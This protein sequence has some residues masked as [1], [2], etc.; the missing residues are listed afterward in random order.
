[1]LD[2]CLY[3]RPTD[4]FVSGAWGGKARAFGQRYERLDAFAETS[5]PPAALMMV[6]ETALEA[7]GRCAS[8]ML[9]TRDLSQTEQFF[10]SQSASGRTTLIGR[11]VSAVI[12]TGDEQDGSMVAS[13][14][15]LPSVRRFARHSGSAV[16]KAFEAEVIILQD[17]SLDVPSAYR[18]MATLLHAS[19]LPLHV[20][21]DLA[22]RIVVSE[23]AARDCLLEEL[24][25]IGVYED[26]TTA[27]SFPLDGMD[28]GSERDEGSSFTSEVA[29]AY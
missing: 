26:D 8:T 11:L 22:S 9:R 29:R 25:A 21:E 5:S 20:V 12:T 1:M 10:L 3:P 23:N 19:A 13:F 27:E 28:V 6:T 16:A 4:M 24:Q 7:C 2:H 18:I 17:T 15:S 14:L